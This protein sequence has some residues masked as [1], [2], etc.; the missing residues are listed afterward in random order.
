MK[1]GGVTDSPRAPGLTL[2]GAFRI[3]W[4]Q[5]SPRMLVALFGFIVALR[6][7]LADFTWWDLAIVAGFG[8]LHPI[9]EWIIH[10]FLLHFRPRTFAGLTIDTRAGA[11]HRRHHASPHDPKYWFIPLSSA[12]VA[13]VVF[14][15]IAR[16]LAP[17]PHLAVTVM[18][19][20]CALGLVYEW[21]HYLCHTSYRGK[22]RWLQRRQ[23]LHRLH[24]FKNEQYWMGVTM[25]AGDILLGTLPDPRAVPTSPNCRTLLRLD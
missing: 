18:A 14:A 16:W 13:F 17:S 15:T 12:L 10:V 2:R 21:T 24:H 1:T 25:H 22:T 3:F 19:T 7:A 9:S 11:D 23:R 20:V 5:Q 6:L 8:V 4:Q